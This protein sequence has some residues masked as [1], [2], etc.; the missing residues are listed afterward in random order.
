MKNLKVWQKL[1]LLGAVFMLPFAVVASKMVQSIDGLGAEFA[2]Q[3]IRGLEYYSPLLMLLKDLQAHRGLTTAAL[4]GEASFRER[5]ARVAD[6]IDRDIKAVDAVDQRLATALGTSTRWSALRAA[7]RDLLLHKTSRLAEESF[8]AHTAVI[9]DAIAL[10]GSIGDG[11]RLSV[12]PQVDSYYLLNFVILKGPE[13][14]EVLAQARDLGT[15]TAASRRRTAE[16]GQEMMRLAT[17]ATFLQARLDKSLAKA[18]QFNDA[19][20]PALEVDVRASSTAVRD[21]GRYINDLASGAAAAAST[22]PQDVYATLSRSVD[23]I[24]DLEQRATASA[25]VL[26]D[27]RVQTFQRQVVY[28]MGAAILGLLIVSAIAFFIIRDITLPLAQVVATANQIATGDLAVTSL[29]Q[30]RK[31]ELGVLGRAFDRMVSALKETVGV[32]ERI[33]S[34]DLSVAVSPRSERDAL[35]QTLGHMVDKLSRLVAEVQRSNVQVNTSV[36]EIAATAKQQQVTTSEIAATTTEIGATSKEISATSKDLVKTM[37]EVSAVAEQ[38][39]TLAGS[40][41]VGL[42]RMEETMRHVMDAAGAINAKLAVLNEKAANINQVVTTITKVADQ[43]NLLSLNAAIE[44]EKAG[45]YGRGFAVVATEIRRLADQTAVA[46]YDIEQMVKEIQSAVSAGV[47]GMDKFSE[48]VRRGIQDV[49]QVGEQLSQII[50]QVQALAPRFEAVSEGMRAQATGAEHIT[51]A[52]AQ[53]SDAAQ[54]TVE[55]LRQSNQA[56]DGLNQAATGMRSGV[57]RFKLVA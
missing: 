10:I 48:E 2:R 5:A 40:G 35:G 9:E 20:R 34:G 12:D 33:A 55:A 1:G 45:E 4:S 43:T 52:L 46:T 15:M 7:C 24:V 26:L 32:A 38:T 51:Q 53:L 11:A 57:S 6:D 47:M 39:A 37:S 50:H 29:S 27:A 36:N 3:E 13:L 49:Q 18:L 41:Q 8:E 25:R 42:T 16:Q 54:Q 22:S 14:T 28:A 56:I 30:D 31:D 17:L 19:L 23:G 21:A 44:A